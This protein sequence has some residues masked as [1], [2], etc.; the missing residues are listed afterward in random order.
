MESDWVAYEFANRP[1]V[2]SLLG[3]PDDVK[4]F[5]VHKRLRTT[6]HYVSTL[7]PQEDIVFKVSWDFIE[8]NKVG[9]GLP[10]RRRVRAG[11]TL[12]LDANPNEEDVFLQPKF[13]VL[14]SEQ[15]GYHD[16]LSKLEGVERLWADRLHVGTSLGDED[17]FGH[18]GPPED[19]VLMRTQAGYH[20][21]LSDLVGFG[22]PQVVRRGKE[23]LRV[24]AC[25]S[26]ETGQSQ[27]RDAMI[28]HLVRQGLLRV[29]E[30]WPTGADAT[31]GIVGH[32]RNDVFSVSH[33]GHM[34]HI[35]PP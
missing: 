18:V 19:E 31:M 17:V 21:G 5:T 27:Q 34:L 24:R 33:T 28:R 32:I 35:T 4:S 13:E 15:A 3:I 26:S 10:Q 25:L 22:R 29:V 14:E 2:R 1:Q 8:P 9:N 16:G 12:V 11:T 6:K 30:A 23:K 7:Q 20:E